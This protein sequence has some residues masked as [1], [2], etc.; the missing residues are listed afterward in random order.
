MEIPIWRSV[1][2]RITAG[3]VELQDYLQRMAGYC[4]TGHTREHVLFFLYGTGVN[5]KSVF[6][7][8]LVAIWGTYAAVAPMT[9]FM[10]SHTDPTRYLTTSPCCARS[11][12][13]SRRKPRSAATGPKQKSSP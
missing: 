10:A 12:S 4:A 5:G 7:N 9:T 3:D 1:L 13:S 2:D 11:D 6:I 8:T